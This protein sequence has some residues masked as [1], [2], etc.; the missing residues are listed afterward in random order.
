MF[1]LPLLKP[2]RFK[3]NLLRLCLFCVPGPRGFQLGY[4]WNSPAH[5]DHRWSSMIRADRMPGHISH[6][7]SGNLYMYDLCICFILT[8]MAFPSRQVPL[9]THI[10]PFILMSCVNQVVW[11]AI[12]PIPHG[13]VLIVSHENSKNEGYIMVYPMLEVHP[14][15]Y[16]WLR[17]IIFSS[18]SHDL[19]IWKANKMVGI[20]HCDGFVGK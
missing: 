12:P 15:M 20:M 5:D 9:I 4:Q 16:C 6:S 17:P 2:L 14:C 8:G 3:G 7:T 13:F 19:S 18:Y 11:L 1:F 10:F